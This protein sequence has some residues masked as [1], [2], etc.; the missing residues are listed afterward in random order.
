[1]CNTPGALAAKEVAVNEK[2]IQTVA[3]GLC[4]I[5]FSWIEHNEVPSLE[6]AADGT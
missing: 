5:Q 4:H 6:I 1:V 2:M 3:C